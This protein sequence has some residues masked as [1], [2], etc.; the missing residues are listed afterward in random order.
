ME[1]PISLYSCFSISAA[2]VN[3]HAFQAVMSHCR[4][5]LLLVFV[6]LYT[7]SLSWCYSLLFYSWCFATHFLVG[8]CPHALSGVRQS[9]ATKPSICRWCPV[10]EA[11][12]ILREDEDSLTM[13][14]DSLSKLTSDIMPVGTIREFM[15]SQQ[16]GACITRQVEISK[17]A[18][19]QETNLLKADTGLECTLDPFTLLHFLCEAALFC[20]H[21]VA[22][23]TL[24]IQPC[25]LM[26][27][28]H[29]SLQRCILPRSSE[30]AASE[31]NS[32]ALNKQS[33]AVDWKTAA[34]MTL[35]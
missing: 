29:C 7:S 21:P 31:G 8:A 15:V 32:A 34:L 5:G 4:T 10:K 16:P 33:A 20:S 3:L 24:S 13:Q 2:S 27:M 22:C 19:A 35:V 17:H 18:S 26:L 11:P 12:Y 28:P 1:A 25:L 14:A 30:T 9:F 23:C 6:R